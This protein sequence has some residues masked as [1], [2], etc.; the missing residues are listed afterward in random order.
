M[1]PKET[2]IS[3]V[4]DTTEDL[5]NEEV[6]T[7]INS[8]LDDIECQYKEVEQDNPTSGT[9]FAADTGIAVVRLLA[10]IAGSRQRIAERLDEISTI[11]LPK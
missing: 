6:F 3:Q 7:E 5:N 10:V 8:V 1:Q 9:P 2:G 4:Q 11:G